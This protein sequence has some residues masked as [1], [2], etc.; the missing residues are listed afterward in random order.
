MRVALLPPQGETSARSMIHR[1]V[2]DEPN[3]LPCRLS[4]RVPGQAWCMAIITRHICSIE[5]HAYLVERPAH[6][7]LA[8]LLPRLLADDI[9]SHIQSSTHF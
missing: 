9:S 1:D 5:F 7:S 6:E 3:L 2:N 8:K 4:P